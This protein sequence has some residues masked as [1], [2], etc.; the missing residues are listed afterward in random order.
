MM[1]DPETAHRHQHLDP[2]QITRACSSLT[3]R[4]GERFPNAGLTSVARQVVR[5]SE[6]S[7]R[8]MGWL[9]RPILWTLGLL[10]GTIV[11]ALI[12]LGAMLANVDWKASAYSS[13]ADLLQGFDAVVNELILLGVAIFFLSSLE[14]RIKRRRALAA[15]HGLRSLAHIVDMHQLTKDPGRLLARGSATPSSP[16]RDLSAYELTRYLGY[17]SELLSL[18]SKIAAL[19]VQKFNDPVTLAAVD[20]LEGLC[21]SLSGKMWQKILIVDR[22]AANGHER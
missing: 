5:S 2:A 4:I 15:L 17:C 12:V 6:D 7:A 3:Q 20:E 13:L 18:L 19:H 11:L 21:A 14:T 22:G 10:V 9:D 1:P 16:K 8:L